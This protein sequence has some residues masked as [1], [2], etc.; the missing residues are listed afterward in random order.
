[1]PQRPGVLADE[2]VLVPPPKVI[3]PVTKVRGTL[4]TASLATITQHGY[5]DRYFAALPAGLHET[6]RSLIASTWVDEEVALQHYL[7]CDALRLSP[8]E[9]HEIGA[10]VGT[11]IRET[12]L[13]SLLRAAK[14]AGTTPWT[15]LEYLPRLFTRVTVGGAAAVYKLGPKEARVEWYGMR[16]VSTVYFSTAFRGANQALLEVFCQK[17]YVSE[18]KAHRGGDWAF[19]G[20]WV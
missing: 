3:S 14:E 8:L 1:V 5:R 20:S 11:R 17:A 10:A 6:M 19:R 4:I 2:E 9:L 16:A 12:F 13:G 18:T 15:Y 7:A